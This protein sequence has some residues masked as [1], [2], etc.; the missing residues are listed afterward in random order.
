MKFE[1][2][3]A[4]E[5]DWR[6]LSDEERDKFKSFVREK[7][8]PACERRAEDPSRAWP[9]SARVSQLTEFPGIMETTWSFSGPDGRATFEWVTVEGEPRIRWRRVGGHAIFK[10]P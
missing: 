1:R 2:T 7:F 9:K 5:G 10:E 6:R 8:H 3:P 4:F